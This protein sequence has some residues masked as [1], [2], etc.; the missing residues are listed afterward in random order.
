MATRNVRDG[1]VVRVEKTHGLDRAGQ[2]QPAVVMV[3]EDELAIARLL[4]YNLSQA[5]FQV[6]VAH[7]G[8]EA[9]ALVPRCDPDVLV[10][11]VMLP[12]IS[13]MEVCR[14]LRQA[15]SRPAIIMLTA[16]ADEMDRVLGLELGADDYVT[17]PF[18]PR[19]L[20]ARVKAVLRRMTG[21]GT[22]PAG[23]RSEVYTV[24]DLEVRVREREVYRN[25]RLVEL[26]AREF[27]LLLF[28]A[29]HAGAAL[30]RD[31]LLSGVWG[32]DNPGDTRMVDVHISHLREKLEDDP[33]RPQYIQT[34][35]GVGYKLASGGGR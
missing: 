27:D 29:R 10:L 6:C 30:S 11:D 23:T 15:G 3:V 4:E 18:S 28:L 32:Y 16:R 35:R 13:G 9:L 31:Q 34:V 1:E 5:G 33:K 14:Q 19:E 25:G 12:G 21:A 8:S 20:V 7:S 22:D 2:D 24:Q 26:T 17:K